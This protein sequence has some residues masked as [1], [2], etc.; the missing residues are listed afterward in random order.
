[1]KS[2]SYKGKETLGMISTLAVNCT[3]I[4]D[5]SQDARKTAAETASDEMLMGAVWALCEFSLL[6]SQQNHSNLSFTALDDELE[7][8]YEKKIAFRDPKMS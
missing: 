3:P 1:L 2:G 4:S 8:F 6:V 5:C 7:P